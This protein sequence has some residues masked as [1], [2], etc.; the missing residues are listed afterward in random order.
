MPAGAAPARP[1]VSTRNRL[2]ARRSLAASRL[3]LSLHG[4]RVRLTLLLEKQM[5][6]MPDLLESFL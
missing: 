2:G 4:V 1:R 6:G 3:G 5:N